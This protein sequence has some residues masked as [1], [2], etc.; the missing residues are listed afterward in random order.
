LEKHKIGELGEAIDR[1]LDIGAMTVD[2]IRIFVDDSNH[3]ENY[4]GMYFFS[5][6]DGMH[7]RGQG[8]KPAAV[9]PFPYARCQTVRVRGL[10]TASGKKP[11]VS[12]NS[13]IEKSTVLIEG[14]G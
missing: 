13:Q 2:V 6:P 14:D 5:D 7:D 10:T 8:A 9:R 12:P 3:P 11:R 4:Q 1:A